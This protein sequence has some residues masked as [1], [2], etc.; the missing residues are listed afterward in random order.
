[1]EEFETFDHECHF[2]RSFDTRK[3][4]LSQRRKRLN[5][6]PT[7]FIQTDDEIRKDNARNN[8]RCMETAGGT[9]RGR[10]SS[11]TGANLAGRRKLHGHKSKDYKVS[12]K[13]R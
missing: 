1:M 5:S 13:V 9:F 3:V 6:V 8:V 7:R 2:S 11:D 12:D 10:V 4:I